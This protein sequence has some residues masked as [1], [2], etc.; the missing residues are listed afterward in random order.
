MTTELIPAID[1]VEGRCVR[2]HQGRFDQETR[3][4]HDPVELA[5]DYA[6]A[7]A[8]SLHVVDLDGARSGKASQAPLIKAMQKAAGGMVQTGGGIRTTEQIEALLEHGISRVV[9]GTRVVEEPEVFGGWL[10]AYGADHLVAA[11]D[12]RAGKDGTFVPTTAGWTEDSATT[13]DDLLDQLTV[14]GLKH[15][16]CTDISRDGTLTGPNVALYKA[17]VAR[18]LEV[19]ASGGVGGLAD[20]GALSGIGVSGIIVGKALLEG[21]FTVAE[22]LTCLQGA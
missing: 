18:D 7:G 20:L 8:T 6:G 17:L 21:R 12:V 11:I 16:L 22:A 14:Y 2:L 4:D 19:Q 15:V 3:Y 13:L 1:L 5:R 9:V 10:K